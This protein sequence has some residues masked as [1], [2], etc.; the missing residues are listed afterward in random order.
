MRI[1]ASQDEPTGTARIRVTNA[2]Y[3]EF[4]DA[5]HSDESDIDLGAL[6]PGVA[7][8]LNWLKSAV[9]SQ[10][11][12]QGPISLRGVPGKDKSREVTTL[13]G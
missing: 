12:T 10:E 8:C 9:S 6:K 1:A 2:R 11:I 3:Y 5:V 7:S 13:G 4:G